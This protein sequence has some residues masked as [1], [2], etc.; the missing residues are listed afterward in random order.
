[1]FDVAEIK[2]LSSFMIRGSPK[3]M[4][5]TMAFSADSRRV[6]VAETGLDTVAEVDL[7]TG[8]VL[9]RIAA[10]RNGDGLGISKRRCKL[11]SAANDRD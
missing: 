11:G 7:V 9:R 10:G 1:M 8:N 6:Y 5:V 4:Q 3:A 2:P